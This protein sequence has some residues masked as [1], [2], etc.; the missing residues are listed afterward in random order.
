MS[1]FSLNFYMFYS[2][3][4]SIS[5][6]YPVLPIE[7]FLSL[8]LPMNKV[9]HECNNVTTPCYPISSPFS[10]KWS[11]LREVTKENLNF[12][13]QKRS[14]SLTRGS[15]YSDLTWKLFVFW[16]TGRLL[17]V[18]FF[19]IKL[20]TTQEWLTPITISDKNHSISF[21]LQRH[22][23]RQSISQFS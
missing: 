12:Q 5:R 22:S 23:F 10:V 13:L 11:G 7:K 16:K 14:R 6:K 1:I 4:K 9:D 20:Y 8:K 21:L 2:S 15:K 19:C 18:V 3:E 17:E